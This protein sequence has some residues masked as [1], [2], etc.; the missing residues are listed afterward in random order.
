MIYIGGVGVGDG[1]VFF[2][3]RKTNGK[4]IPLECALLL[5]PV[6]S[7]GDSVGS[8]CALLLIPVIDILPVELY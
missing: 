6:D 1:F 8:E 5:I 7:V 3:F 4:K 2:H